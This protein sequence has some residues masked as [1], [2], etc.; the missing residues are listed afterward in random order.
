MHDVV[1]Y[2]VC[3]DACSALGS[4]IFEREINCDALELVYISVWYVLSRGI[5]SKCLTVNE[6]MCYSTP[7]SYGA[8]FTTMGGPYRPLMW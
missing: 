7:S 6:V 4:V 2:P 1:S 3:L 8:R 5:F